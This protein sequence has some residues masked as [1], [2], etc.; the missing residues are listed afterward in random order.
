MGHQLL[1]TNRSVRVSSPPSSNSRRLTWWVCLCARGLH[2]LSMVPMYL[3]DNALA[4]CAACTATCSAVVC[5]CLA[6]PLVV[7]LAWWEPPRAQPATY[8]HRTNT[9][10]TRGGLAQTCGVGR[11]AGGVAS[12]ARATIGKR[13]SCQT[14]IGRG[15]SSA[16]ST[17]DLLASRRSDN[18]WILVPIVLHGG[19][20]LLVHGRLL[21]L[22]RDVGVPNVEQQHYAS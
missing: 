13:C 4:A 9:R 12:A 6:C 5:R 8:Y 21:L 22:L 2:T 19:L 20:H 16:S 3:A 10:R 1:C 11:F 7:G 17:T 14:W 15:Q 18:L